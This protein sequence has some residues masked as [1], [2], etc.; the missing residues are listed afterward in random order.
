MVPELNVLNVPVNPLHKD[1]D[2]TMQVSTKMTE[3]SCLA[4]DVPFQLLEGYVFDS[5]S[6]EWLS[7]LSFVMIFLFHL[8]EIQGV[9]DR[10]GEIH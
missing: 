4:F 8:R 7:L 10:G 1:A 2:Q 6:A 9:S 5:V 3:R